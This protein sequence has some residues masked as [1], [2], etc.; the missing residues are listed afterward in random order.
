MLARALRISLRIL[1]IS[2]IILEPLQGYC[3]RNDESC[4]VSQ[5]KQINVDQI[6]QQYTHLHDE[7]Y[8]ID[9]KVEKLA[10]LYKKVN[11]LP[12]SVTTNLF[13]KNTSDCIKDLII[14]YEKNNLVGMKSNVKA[15]CSQY[16]TH[17]HTDIFSNYLK[18]IQQYSQNLYND[19]FSTKENLEIGEFW[20]AHYRKGDYTIRHNHGNLLDGFVISG[21]YYAYVEENSSPIIFDGL[22]PVYPKNDS[23]ILFSSQTDHEV[24]PTDGERIIMSFNIRKTKE[25]QLTIEEQNQV[26]NFIMNDQ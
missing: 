4:Q 8:H 12:T 15:W 13:G 25:T 5:K 20:V 11:Y 23:L 22:N 7:G 19:I 18:F 16:E 17:L 24:P 2:L 21:C 14:N 26:K 3:T 6:V 9:D 10:K 1:K